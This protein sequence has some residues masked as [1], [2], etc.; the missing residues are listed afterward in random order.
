MARINIERYYNEVDKIIQYGGSK[1][2]TSIRVPFQNLLNSYCEQ[3]DFKLIAELGYK[4]PSGKTVYPDG[5]VKDALQ[6]DW[7]YWESKDEY[8]DLDVEIEKKFEKGY[9]QDNIIFED[10]ETAVLIQGGTEMLRSPIRDSTKLDRLIT[11]FINYERPEIRSFREAIER[12]KAD[13]PTVANTLRDKIKEQAQTN[14]KFKIAR[15]DFLELCRDSINP[16][17]NYDDTREM[18]I[19]HILTDDI[20]THIYGESHFH[21][22]NNIAKQLQKVVDTFFIGQVRREIDSSIKNY[23][24]I[25]KSKASN[26]ENHKEKQK[27]LKVIYENFYKAYNPKGADRLGIIYTPDE[28]VDFLIKNTDHLLDKYFGKLLSDENVEILDPATGTGTFIA[29]LIDYIPKD[30]LDYKYENDFHANEVSILP[31]YIANLNIEYTYNQKTKK[32]KEF[33]NICF[34]DT[35]DNLGFK[36]RLGH[37]GVKNLELFGG[38]SVKNIQR[39]KNQNEKDITVIFGNPPYYA[40]Q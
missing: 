27:F 38:I 32:Y 28:I 24:S 11:E 7:G 15:K 25:I 18:I 30:K 1:K 14:E 36:G 12:F 17:I 31:Y 23:Y 10:S 20:F 3:K 37:K 26:I 22:E 2:E 21:K 19:Q 5:T 33:K 9:P 40:N 35:L 16:H 6:L 39:I 13:I 34:V 8:D 4:T 29:E